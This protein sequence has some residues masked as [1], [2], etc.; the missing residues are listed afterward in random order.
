M[1]K[2]LIA[3]ISKTNTTK[4][5][6]QYI[7]NELQTNDTSV[8]VLTFNEVENILDYSAVIVGSPING[9]S[10]LPEAH[11]FVKSNK[12][13]LKSIPVAYF[14]VSYLYK[15]S[16]KMWRNI[17]DKSLKKS[18]E[19]VKPVVIGKFSGRVEKKFP[20]FVSFIFGVKKTLPLNLVDFKQVDE[21]I[22]QLKP[23]IK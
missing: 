7:K 16:R 19:L 3:Y 4:E 22:A 23:Y 17:I 14:F 13:A 5:I 21:F 18:S 8:D 9:M 20:A 10:W 2:I 11:N 15:D 12:D 1:K 6:S